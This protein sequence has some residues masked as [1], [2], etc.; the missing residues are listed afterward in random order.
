MELI[1]SKREMLAEYFALNINDNGEVE[2]IPMLLKGYMPS[3]GKL[4]SFLLRLG[5]R[6]SLL[7]FSS[8]SSGLFPI[9]TNSVN[10]RSFGPMK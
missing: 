5:G 3:I 1:M 6:V 7:L 4:P 9:V 2:S 8:S 10:Y